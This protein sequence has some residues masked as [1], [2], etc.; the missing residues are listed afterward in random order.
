MKYHIRLLIN[1]YKSPEIE[2]VILYKE[3]FVHEFA[4]SCKYN[5][6]EEKESPHKLSAVEYALELIADIDLSDYIKHHIQLCEHYY[7][8]IGILDSIT[9][10]LFNIK[11][12]K[13][14]KKSIDNYIKENNA[15]I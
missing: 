4:I 5:I 10:Q 11:V 6:W 7:E 2:Y 3:A 12:Q 14:T 9:Y 8:V 15:N 1:C 13:V